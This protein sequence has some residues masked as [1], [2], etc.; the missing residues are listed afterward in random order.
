MKKLIEDITSSFQF[1]REYIM[2]LNHLHEDLQSMK[3]LK[4]PWRFIDPLR[5]VGPDLLLD[6]IDELENKFNSE[7]VGGKTA[8]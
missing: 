3:I 4:T 1:R 5:V 6:E 2:F 7:I 8:F